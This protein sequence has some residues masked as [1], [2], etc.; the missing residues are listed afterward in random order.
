MTFLPTSINTFRLYLSC[1]G[2]TGKN[3]LSL[4]PFYLF[5]LLTI[6]LLKFARIC[7]SLDSG[8]TLCSRI[9]LDLHVNRKIAII[10]LY[11]L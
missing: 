2:K 7:D 10:Y 8:F 1:T 3:G 9:Y 6:V 5:S 11:V 4:S